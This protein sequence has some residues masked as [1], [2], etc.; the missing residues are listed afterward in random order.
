[1]SIH[2]KFQVCMCK[3]FPRRE[4]T[5]ILPDEAKLWSKVVGLINTPNSKAGGVTVTPYP[6]RCVVWSDSCQSFRHSGERKMASPCGCI[7][8]VPDY[9]GG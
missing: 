9:E 2:D 8:N 5:S 1:M 4:G 7:L 3:D 6:Y